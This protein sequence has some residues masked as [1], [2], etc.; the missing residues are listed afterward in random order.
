MKVRIVKTD[1]GYVPQVYQNTYGK[2]AWE[3]V[4]YVGTEFSD[5]D[6]LFKYCTYYT[7]WGAKKSLFKYLKKLGKTKAQMDAFESFKKQLENPNVVYE[8][9]I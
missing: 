3:G 1:A 2:Y 9:E 6:Y 5:P 7:L 8:A 4:T